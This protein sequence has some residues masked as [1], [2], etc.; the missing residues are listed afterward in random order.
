MITLCSP[1]KARLPTAIALGSFDG[2]H[3]GHRQV[4]EKI[5]QSGPGIAS[6]VSFW[7]H[8]REVLYGESRLR[9]D[10]PEEKAALLGK[11]GVEQ[12]VL[13]PF[14]KSLASLKPEEFIKK[15]LLQTL[16]TK[17]IAVG[18]DFLFGKNRTGNSYILKSIANSFG[19]EVD[20][21]KI[22]KDTEGRI[23]SS[24]IRSS[25]SI[26]DINKAQILMG[27]PYKFEGRV[28]SGKGLGSKI[29][30][31][32][33]NLEV[34][35]R[36]FLPGIGVYACWVW[37]SNQDSAFA[38]VMNLGPQPTVDPNSPSAVEVHLLDKK[39]DLRG[40][41]LIVQPIKRLRGQTKFL[42]INDLSNQIGK[43]AEQ[44][45]KILERIRAY[46]IKD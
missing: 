7:P 44:A 37:L 12:L 36:K 10:L 27:R 3:E 19:V 33:A 22:I 39:L 17:R 16:N 41:N 28:V 14:N 6:V 35:G 40:N 29:G 20:I 46:E 5:T 32:T 43:D 18:E 25:L 34:D 21:I 45:R 42:N 31:P 15:I 13:I 26:G 30:W 38:S 4:I 2:L 24:R 8:P 1:E 11:M 23:S 9:L